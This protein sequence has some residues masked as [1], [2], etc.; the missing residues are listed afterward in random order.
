MRSVLV[1][2]ERK[3]A[4]DIIRSCLSQ[5]YKIG[6]ASTKD[7]ALNLLKKNRYDLIFIDLDIL[8][9]NISNKNY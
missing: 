9:K 7:I 6:K 2:S 1:T 4:F 3:D 5:G 8:L